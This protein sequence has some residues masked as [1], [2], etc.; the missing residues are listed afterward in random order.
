MFRWQIHAAFSQWNLSRLS[1]LRK[2]VGDFL[3]EMF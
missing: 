2:Q 1:G 3:P